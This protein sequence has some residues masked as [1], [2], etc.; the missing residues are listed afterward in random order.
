MNKDK[1]NSLEVIKQVEY[2][3]K[4]LR[5]N[6]TLT[7]I[8]KDLGVGRSTI[9]DRFK[10]LDY[11][12]CKDLNQYIFNE[13]VYCHTDVVQS[14]TRALSSINTDSFKKYNVSDTDVKTLDKTMKNKLVNVMNEYDILMEMIE[15][16]KSNSNVLQ[17]NI[18][19]DLP[20]AE[21]ELT[22]FRVN[23]EILKDFNDF[24]KE[25]KEYRKIDLV[26]MALKEYME[27]HS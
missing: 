19:I 8:S 4:L 18:I 20:T 6:M 15:L 5:D 12:Y 17:S 13:D 23:K 3:N 1:F 9:R 7:S 27:N 22:S 25:Q 16:Y 14:N 26:S 11:I 21:S 10:K 2:I 24:V